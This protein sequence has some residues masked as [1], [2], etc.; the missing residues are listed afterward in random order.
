MSA[1]ITSRTV[2]GIASTSRVGAVSTSVAS[3]H[4]STSD[5]TEA[6]HD[7]DN[8]YGAD[9]DGDDLDTADD[10]VEELKIGVAGKNDRQ[11]QQQQ[12]QQHRRR[13]QPQQSAV[14]TIR[15][16]TGDEMSPHGTGGS[17]RSTF[18]GAPIMTSES[19]VRVAGGDHAAHG[20]SSVTE[21]AAASSDGAVG[22]SRE[23]WIERE[24]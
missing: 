6:D 17:S 13:D 14:F 12:Q 5:G 15:R 21:A 8:S 9:Y 10:D 4:E 18:A 11:Q 24:R 3:T 2:R 22:I 20:T 1:A 19:R 23:Q 7:D 16:E